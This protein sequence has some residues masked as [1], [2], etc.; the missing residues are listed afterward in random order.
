MILRKLVYAMVVVML[1]LLTVVSASAATVPSGTLPVVVEWVKVDGDQLDTDA[2]HLNKI[3]R[4]EQYEVKV[5]IYALDD[6]DPNTNGVLNDL[7]VTARMDGY[8]HADQLYAVDY[9]T[10]GRLAEGQTDT[11]KFTLAL[12]ERLDVGNNGEEYT[13][14]LTVGDKTRDYTIKYLLHVE[15]EEHAF[16]IKDVFFSPSSSVAPGRTLAANVYL[17]NIGNDDEEDGIKVSMNIPALGVSA[18][19]YIDELDN[20]ESTTS[21]QLWL[22]VPRCSAPGEYDAIFEIVFKDGDKSV[23]T[24]RTVKVIEDPYSTGCGG[25]SSEQKASEKTVIAIADSV[26]EVKQGEGVAVYPLTLTNAG[27]ETKTYVVEADGFSDWAKVSLSPSSVVVVQP[28]EAK[29]VYAYVTASE[30]ATPGEH[31]FSLTVKSGSETLKELALKAN[32]VE[33]SNTP[34]DTPGKWSSVKKGLEVGL[35]V[36]IILLVVLGLVIGFN[37]LREGDDEDFDEDEDK[38]YY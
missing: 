38:D 28:E 37:K 34:A 7:T 17:K 25:E 12:P 26:Q 33:G 18:V 21:E 32:V 19:D 15:A 23:T 3:D 4:N 13:L 36:L 30:A 16:L 20:D 9:E 2:Q 24:T 11:V 29:A 27:I 1:A 5:K 14:T 8:D 10:V 35:I 6:N 31:M 22:Q